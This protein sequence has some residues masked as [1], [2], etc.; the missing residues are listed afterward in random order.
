VEKYGLPPKNPFP[1]DEPR[2]NTDGHGLEK[3]KGVATKYRKQEKC[4]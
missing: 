3:G 4:Q 1:K 2:M